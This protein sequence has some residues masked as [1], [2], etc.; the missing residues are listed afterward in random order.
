M[1]FKEYF[2]D[3][4]RY[5]GTFQKTTDTG[6]RIAMVF[7]RHHCECRGTEFILF[8]IVTKESPDFTEDRD[9]LQQRSA[10]LAKVPEV[11]F[12]CRSPE[13]VWKT[14]KKWGS[15]SGSRW[16]QVYVVNFRHFIDSH[17][18]RVHRGLETLLPPIKVFF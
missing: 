11:I 3:F 17:T 2:E 8:D 5:A 6:T 16:I 9:A 12:D 13:Y 18:M 15:N 1:N 4:G 10:I 14:Y 7:E